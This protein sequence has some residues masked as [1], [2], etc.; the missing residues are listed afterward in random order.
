MMDSSETYGVSR[1]KRQRTSGVVHRGRRRLRRSA[2]PCLNRWAFCQALGIMDAMG[3][4]IL[5]LEFRCSKFPMNG[6]LVLIH[7]AKLR[8]NGISNSATLGRPPTPNGFGGGPRYRNTDPSLNVSAKRVRAR[9]Y[10]VR[11][12]PEDWG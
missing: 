2:T 8:V 9:W 3:I 7:C 5:R 11:G 10:S 4:R 1:V 12:L 6:M